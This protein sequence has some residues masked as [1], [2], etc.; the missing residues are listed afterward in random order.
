MPD[1]LPFHLQQWALRAVPHVEAGMEIHAAI[2]LAQQ[3]YEAW[4]CE[5]GERDNPTPRARL[6]RKA[7]T[8]TIWL[9]I[10]R[11]N[12]VSGLVA[13]GEGLLE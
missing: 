10:T 2:A 4:L 13:E 9:E 7:L 6:V 8:A 3:E 12:A 1:P 5:L 11:A